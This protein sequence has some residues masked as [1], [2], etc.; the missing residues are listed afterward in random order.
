MHHQKAL[1]RPQRAAHRIG[2]LLMFAVL[3]LAVPAAPAQ[4]QGFEEV[5]VTP[6]T[7]AEFQEEIGKL[8]LEY[9]QRIAVEQAHEAYKDRIVR[10]IETGAEEFMQM[11][12]DLQ[13]EGMR[14]PSRK[15]IVELLDMRDE[16]TRRIRTL[17]RGLFD[18]IQQVLREDQYAPLDHLRRARERKSYELGIINIGMFDSGTPNI[19]IIT[20]GLDLDVATMVTLEPLLV[21]YEKAINHALHE[22]SD[23]TFAMIITMFDVLEEMGFD[24]DEDME[25]MEM[26]R[27][28]MAVQ[29][30]FNRASQDMQKAGKRVVSVNATHRRRIGALLPPE[31]KER[32]DHDYLRIVYPS[33]FRDHTSAESTFQAALKPEDLSAD[34]RD[35]IQNLDRS[36]RRQYDAIN[37]RMM[38]AVDEQ[39]ESRKGP[40]DFGRGGDFWQKQQEFEAER[41]TLNQTTRERLLA[42]LNAEDRERIAAVQGDLADYDDLFAEAYGGDE[43]SIPDGAGFEFDP[44]DAARGVDQALPAA[45]TPGEL[46]SYAHRMGLPDDRLTI[47]LAVLEEYRKKYDALSTSKLSPLLDGLRVAMYQDNADNTTTSNYEAAQAKALKEVLALEEEFFRDL[48]A[49]LTKEGGE[50]LAD[51]HTARQ[52]VVFD[53]GNEATAYYADDYVD[54]VRLVGRLDLPPAALYALHPVLAQLESD[55]LP[56][57]KSQYET[58]LGW[59]IAQVRAQRQMRNF[60][61]DMETTMGAGQVW[62]EIMEPFQEKLS[63]LA[64][65]RGEIERE[66]V[67]QILEALPPGIAQR[68]QTEFNKY[69][70]PDVYPDRDN[71]EHVFPYVQTLRSLSAGQR[72]ELETIIADHTQRHDAYSEEM[73]ALSDEGPDFPSFSGDD[74]EEVADWQQREMRREILRYL[75]T[76]W[77]ETTRR[78]IRAIL[79]E[80]QASQVRGLGVKK[81]T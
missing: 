67:P 64:E 29:E 34:Q 27:M 76:E 79:S 19:V 62:M 48:A 78:R 39:R 74:R 41:T 20:D 4:G 6:I 17:D 31:A 35:R 58:T 75:R 44:S 8:D 68:F 37:R 73:M 14:I 80:E 9:G 23:E 24:L 2:A 42:I 47:A 32:F 77:N 18:S 15:K 21:D 40:L 53:L 28:A 49:I 36:W 51:I 3:V 1:R 59:E 81:R 56:I 16:L 66:V 57:V 50:R 65:D 26:M 43:M 55:L 7:S 5:L 71:A 54:I 38:A 11:I 46:T 33:V 63:D 70:Y 72:A 25:E 45:I 30:A 10:L 12:Y 61:N 13:S 69:H 22:R 60:A 52:R